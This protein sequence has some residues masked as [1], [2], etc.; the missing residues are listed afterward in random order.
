MGAQIAAHIGVIGEHHAGKTAKGV[1]ARGGRLA[2]A[3][4]LGD[5]DEERLPA[6][7]HHAIAPVVIHVIAS[8]ISDNPRD[9][10]PFVIRLSVQDPADGNRLRRRQRENAVLLGR[11]YRALELAAQVDER[12]AGNAHLDVGVLY[13][14]KLI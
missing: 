3:R 11:E 13:H 5:R 8:D 4:P 12:L 10:D 6:R 7:F 14:I 9:H 2:A 1:E